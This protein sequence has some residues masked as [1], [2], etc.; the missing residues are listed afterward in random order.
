MAEIKDLTTDPDEQLAVS[1]PI[2]RPKQELYDPSEDR[3]LVRGHL[4][5]GLLWL[6]AFL[7]GGALWFIGMGRLDG[8]ALTQS[9]LPSVIALAGTALGFYFGTQAVK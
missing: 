5:R 4:A 1:R 2:D 8:G 9:I 3:E 7:I 6:L